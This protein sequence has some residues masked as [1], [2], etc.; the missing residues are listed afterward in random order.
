MKTILMDIRGI[1]REDEWAELKRN[2]EKNE[3]RIIYNT[4]DLSS[5]EELLIITDCQDT[6]SE[7]KKYGIACVGYERPDSQERI[8]G[9]DMVIQGFGEL[10]YMFFYLVY[11]RHHRLPWDIAS[12]GRLL[13]RETTMEDFD[14]LY[15]LY[16]DPAI[17]RFMP[18]MD[19][20]KEE[21]RRQMEL[22]IHNMY[23]FYG[24]GL[25]S[26]IE[27]KTGRLIGRA[28]LENGHLKGRNVIEL[29]YM[30][31]TP[32]Q[33]KGFAYEAVRAI[34]S[35]AF[36]VVGVKKLYVVISRN[37]LR[38]LRLVRKLGFR[39]Q[40]SEAGDICTFC[41]AQGEEKLLYTQV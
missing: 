2:L 25:W 34:I 9:T 29:G 39:E 40:E 27:K 12:T 4:E 13:I 35:Y 8:Y 17:T 19:E 24:Y 1:Y 20:D 5:E 22:Y 6:V 7:A 23:A 37:N 14:A 36:E 21:E 41:L 10:E 31:G 30:L 38:S 33:G 26:I 32:Y 16:Q 18:G 11:Q 3:V 28:G 15:E